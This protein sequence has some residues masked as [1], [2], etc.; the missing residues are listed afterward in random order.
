MEGNDDLFDKN[1]NSLYNSEFEFHSDNV[2]FMSYKNLPK[3]SF[4]RDYTS[5]DIFTPRDTSTSGLNAR[6]HHQ[7]VLSS[8]QRT[9]SPQKEPSTLT[10][11]LTDDPAGLTPLSKGKSAFG[12]SKFIPRMASYYEPTTETLRPDS[13]ASS[14]K[15]KAKK[16]SRH[17]QISPIPPI[18]SDSD[19]EQ[20]PPKKSTSKTV[21]SKKKE[22]PF[23]KKPNILDFIDENNKNYKMHQDEIFTNDLEF[24]SENVRMRQRGESVASIRRT[25]VANIFPRHS[26]KTEEITEAEDST[27]S[28]SKQA[29][30]TSSKMADFNKALVGMIKRDKSGKIRIEKDNKKYSIQEESFSKDEDLLNL[31][32]QKLRSPSF[33]SLETW[34]DKFKFVIGHEYFRQNIMRILFLVYFRFLVLDLYRLG[35]NDFYYWLYPM[36]YIMFALE[37]VFY[38]I[39]TPI[40]NLKINKFWSPAIFALTFTIVPCLN[41]FLFL[42]Y[43]HGAIN[44]CSTSGWEQTLRS[45]YF[46]SWF[47][48]PIVY[49]Q[50][51]T[52]LLVLG[53]AIFMNY[54]INAEELLTGADILNFVSQFDTRGLCL[55]SPESLYWAII[56]FWNAAMFRF[57]LNTKTVKARRVR[58]VDN[59]E[60]VHWFWYTKAWAICLKFFSHE[61]PFAVVRLA[62]L[63][64]G[65]SGEMRIFFFVKNFVACAMLARSFVHIW[66]N[67]K[68]ATQRV[69]WI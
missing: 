18:E 52:V 65:D 26:F 46:G 13:P 31:K 50:F 53:R 45:I 32:K 67:K 64:L 30:S 29:S 66:K 8:N 42:R 6:L 37:I 40:F 68:S 19:T 34:K 48:S 23:V 25:S 60:F 3:V 56:P 62:F 22:S 10:R 43:V 44:L 5:D 35:R 41:T 4:N 17:R 12:K 47:D 2:N 16:I 20:P 15:K 69:I 28:W 39:L 57:F 36:G 38:A 21:E 27:R 61:L 9:I 7:K 33:A 11:N 14:N 49:T 59:S 63:C 54:K 24:H 55:V 1:R 51:F 58:R